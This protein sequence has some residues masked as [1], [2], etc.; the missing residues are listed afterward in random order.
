[1]KIVFQKI[2]N[3]KV[4]DFPEVPVNRITFKEIEN[5]EFLVI[6]E[7]PEVPASKIVFQKIENIEALEVPD[8]AAKI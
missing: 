3:L 1:M 4:L 5:I 7:V 2:E 8:D 6:S